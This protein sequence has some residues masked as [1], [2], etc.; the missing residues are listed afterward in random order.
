MQHA[1]SGQ[2]LKSQSLL[3]S[4]ISPS[5]LDGSI[6]PG[7]FPD[8]LESLHLAG[9]FSNWLE[10]FQIP[11]KFSGCM[12]SNRESITERIMH[13]IMDMGQRQFIQGVLFH[14]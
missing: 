12:L 6:L 5:I 1:I 14:W 11:G 2:P 4:Y 3:Q 13:I 7:K 10:S 9:E 8:H